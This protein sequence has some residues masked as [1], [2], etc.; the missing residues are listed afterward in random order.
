MRIS[1]KLVVNT[2]I[3]VIFSVLISTIAIGWMVY[4]NANGFLEEMAINRFVSLR[5]SKVDQIEEHYN[6][7]TKQIVTFAHDYTVIK[8]MQDFT[9]AYN[10]Y[11]ALANEVKFNPDTITKFMGQFATEY[12]RL[13]DGQYIDAMKL[14]NIADERS[15]ALQYNYILQNPYPD[16]ER[17]KYNYVQ[18]GSRYS[19]IHKQFH[20]I[21]KEYQEKF[22]FYDILLVE[23]INGDVVY[24]VNKQ[25]DYASSLLHG[26]FANSGIAEAFRNANAATN[27]DYYAITDF[28]GY[29]PIY[30]NVAAFLAAPVFDEQDRKI[31]VLIFHISPDFNN[32]VMTSNGKWE[33]S[34]WGKTGE[35]Y[36]LGHDSIMRTMSRFFVEDPTTY[37]QQMGKLGVD[38]KTVHQIEAK[39]TTIGLQKISSVGAKK[40]VQGETGVAYYKDY[41]KQP[42]IAAYAQLNIPG[43]NW[44]VICGID[45]IEAFAA[46]HHLAHKVIYYAIIIVLVLSTIAIIIGLELSKEVSTPI[47]R[48]SNTIYWLAKSQDLTKRVRISSNDELGHMARAINILLENL[49]Y[50]CKTTIESSKQMQSVASKL[51]NMNHSGSLENVVSDDIPTAISGQGQR[52]E[53]KR[54]S[55]AEEEFELEP[56][57]ESESASETQSVSQ[58]NN[59]SLAAETKDSLAELSAKLE[60]LSNQF[61]IFEEES[62]RTNGW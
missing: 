28:A 23:A 29:D 56:E 46:A 49:Q 48:F 7:L 32:A 24:S 37:V 40:V 54:R 5:D 17:S 26:P 58:L 15:F 45:T 11:N 36:I 13:N 44:G 60:Q 50:A 19:Q 34:G 41:R 59:V 25:L 55:V 52:Q 2:V 27:K 62:E 10:N 20:R 42:V 4:F 14:F 30:G 9:S 1:T 33:Q 38:E 51:F 6:T 21:F 8:A 16:H 31:G 12:A 35:T 22:K 47:E 61:K 57:T 18:D 53:Q 3:M 39:K 43:L